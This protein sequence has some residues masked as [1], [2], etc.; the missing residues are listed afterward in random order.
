MRKRAPRL[1]RSFQPWLMPE[2]SPPHEQVRQLV[3][4]RKATSAKS[5]RLVPFASRFAT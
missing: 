2:S 3:A 5:G 1:E 4:L